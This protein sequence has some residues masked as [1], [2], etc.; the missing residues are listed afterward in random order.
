MTSESDRMRKALLAVLAKFFA[1]PSLPEELR[2]FE[3]TAQA[4][5]LVHAAAFAYHTGELEGGQRDLA[6]AVRIDPAIERNCYKRLIDLLLGW[7]N[8]PRTTE[9]V[10]FLQRIND[11]PPPGLPRFR[12]QLR[13]A[14]ADVILG[15]LFSESR[16]SWSKKRKDLLKVILYKPDWLLNRGVLRMLAGAWLHL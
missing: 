14:I 5:A 4:T 11:N 2:A 16:E 13:R 6:E 9:P 15:G 7:S 10:E 8:N 1:Q 12:K 3:T